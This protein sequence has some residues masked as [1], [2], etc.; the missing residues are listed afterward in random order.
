MRR[1][2]SCVRYMM[3]LGVVSFVMGRLVPRRWIRPGRFPWRS[4]SWEPRLYR[5]LRIKRWQDKVPDMS[6]VFTRLMPAKRLTRETLCDLSRMIDETCVA[7]GTHVL[8]CVAGLYMLHLWP[9]AGG[10]ALTAV[11]ILLGNL[12]FILIQ[13]YN[14]PRLVRLLALQKH[15]HTKGAEPEPPCAP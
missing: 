10:A 14:R 13:R 2:W 15:K 6:R 3:G 7:E 11:Y 12:P 8:L 1:L 4:A 5:A 9:G